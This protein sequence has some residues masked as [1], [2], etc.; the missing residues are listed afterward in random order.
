MRYVIEIC[1][2]SLGP[3]LGALLVTNNS[4]CETCINVIIKESPNDNIKLYKKIVT[5]F[6]VS[7]I[8][9]HVAMCCPKRDNKSSTTIPTKC[10]LVSNQFIN[11]GDATNTR[12]P[13]HLL[14]QT[15]RN[16]T[17]SR[18]FKENITNNFCV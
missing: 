3:S 11:Y 18:K 16:L 7:T 15:K 14:M 4:T 6:V 9:H 13:G 10:L 8:N 2:D 5:N 17:D 1:S 12:L